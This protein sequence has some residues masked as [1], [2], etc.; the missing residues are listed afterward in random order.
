MTNE[1]NPNSQHRPPGKLSWDERRALVLS[2]V[3]GETYVELGKKH[4]LSQNTARYLVHDCLKRVGADPKLRDL[5][6]LCE[7]SAD[8]LPEIEMTATLPGGAVPQVFEQIP[9]HALKID[10]AVVVRLR[11]SGIETIKELQE[12]PMEQVIAI[13]S[14]TLNRFERLQEL[15]NEV[16]MQS[17]QTNNQADNQAATV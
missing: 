16:R 4:G 1:E 6:L 15:I 14:V 10:T 8:V 9:L 11:E 3:N 17:T 2:V 7:S 5:H 13:R 12:R